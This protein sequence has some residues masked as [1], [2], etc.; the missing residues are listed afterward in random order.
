MNVELRSLWEIRR[1]LVD[2]NVKETILVRRHLG[3]RPD[4]GEAL[5][6][7]IVTAVWSWKVMWGRKPQTR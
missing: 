2:L 5:G 3:G 7:A 4:G 1:V 6:E